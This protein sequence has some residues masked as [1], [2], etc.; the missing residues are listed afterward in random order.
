MRSERGLTLVEMLVAMLIFLIVLVSTMSAIGSQTRG[1][2]KGTEEMGILQNLRYGV[3]QMEQ[4][5][6]MAG[7]NTA[8]RQ[9]QAVYAG[10]TAFSFN[11]DLV[12]NTPGDISAVYVDPD[13][14]VG[15]VTAMTTAMAG[16]IPGSSPAFTY[17]LANFA[18][19]PAETITF[20]FAADAET[21]RGDDFVLLRQVNDRPAE[22]LVRGVLAPAGGGPFFSYRYLSVPAG[23]GNPT[24][25]AVPAGWLPLRHTSAQHGTITDVGTAARI[26]SLRAVDVQYR[27][28]NLRTGAAERI[29]TIQ[30]SI[31]M[32]N[33]GVKKL[34]SCGDAPIFTSP[35]TATWNAAASTLDVTWVASVDEASGEQ[36]VIRYVIWRRVTPV[37]AWGDPI[38]S[39]PSGAPPYSFPDADV[40][41]GETYQYAV[42]AQDCTPSLSAQR[43]SNSV[44]IPVI[45]VP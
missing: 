40:L 19:S 24:L 14:P 3:Q 35:V 1:F 16:A 8:D 34:Q 36:D 10:T 2:A 25:A 30:T 22:P 42:A 29:R 17:P 27:V 33:L 6:R 13:A 21:A 15:H 31:P 18:A 45:I 28:T 11:A 37:V 44:T 7:A 4:E 39:I 5:V 43:L 32:P 12:S 38:A 9:P 20:W 26:D 23:G 41:Q